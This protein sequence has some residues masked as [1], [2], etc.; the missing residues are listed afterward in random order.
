[1]YDLHTHT[2]MSDG[3]LLPTELIRRAAVLGYTV[4]GITDHADASNID[5]LIA[6]T[7]KVRT[8]AAAYGVRLLNGVELTHIPPAEIADLAAR[9][10]AAGA[11]IVIVHGET[12][13][14]PVAPGTNA[15]ACTCPDVDVLAHPGLITPEDARQA[16]A[17][18]IA[19]EITARGGHNRTNGHIVQLARMTGCRLVV[20]SDGHAPG[21][22]MTAADRMAI[23][24]GAGMTADECA[25][26]LDTAALAVLPR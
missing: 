7:E 13:V 1:M 20:N 10:K 8:S 2:I 21:D 23:A 9:A 12:T 3:E 24:R 25:A 14:E 19:L 17:H 22:L 26:A 18:G 16:A 5:S 15:A 6:A 4:V 11:D